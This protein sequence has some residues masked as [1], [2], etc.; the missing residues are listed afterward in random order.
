MSKYRNVRTTIGDEVYDSKLEATRHMELKLLEKA[1]EVRNIRRQVVFPLMV[2]ET[3]VAK[4]IADFCYEAREQPALY[5]WIP[6]IED[7]KSLPTR[8]NALYR[9]K[10]R[11]MKA[12]GTPIR[13]YVRGQ[14]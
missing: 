3:C 7:A 14:R 11:W 1:G 8:R 6:V 2:G 5:L 12:L 13:E 4:Y 9:L 10:Y